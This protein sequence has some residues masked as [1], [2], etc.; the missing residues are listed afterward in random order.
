MYTV[1]L[2]PDFV[3]GAFLSPGMKGGDR[4]AI[5]LYQSHVLL[6][7]VVLKKNV[8][9]ARLINGQPLM[10]TFHNHF[11]KVLVQFSEHNCCRSITVC[12][13]KTLPLC[14][15]NFVCVCVCQ[16]RSAFETAAQRALNTLGGQKTQ[17]LK[18]SGSGQKKKKKRMAQES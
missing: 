8:L 12:L 10:C 4:T 17:L 13:L 14:N 1:T 15:L 16:L 18:N 6:I 3:F 9:L 11:Q 2:Y 5:G 7:T